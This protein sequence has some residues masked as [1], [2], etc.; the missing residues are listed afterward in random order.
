[1]R[2]Y[3]DRATGPSFPYQPYDLRDGRLTSAAEAVAA[4]ISV[5]GEAI[6]RMLED[7]TD[8]LASGAPIFITGDF[9]EPSHLDWTDET[10]AA[11]LHFGMKVEW[12]TSLRVVDA[13]MTDAY[14]FVHPDPIA[15]PGST[16]TPLAGDDEVHDRID[17]V[18]VGGDGVTAKS[19]RVVGESAEFADVVETPWPSDHRAMVVEVEIPAGP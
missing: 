12:P 14:R 10:A 9:N 13:G 5:R 1:M 6:G 3:A 16:W 8:A 17:F 11:S 15:S 4:A 19:A 2:L 18:Y 7:M